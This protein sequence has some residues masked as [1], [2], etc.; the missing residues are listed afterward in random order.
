M[1]AFKAGFFIE[2]GQK[3]L[4]NKIK[5]NILSCIL[6]DFGCILQP[7]DYKTQLDFYKNFFM[8][9]LTTYPIGYKIRRLRELKGMKQETLAKTM[10][11]TRQ[12]ISK[13]EQSETVEE[14]ILNRVADALE[15]STDAIRK[16][17]EEAVLN[18]ISST[19][20]HTSGLINY[21]PTF[22]FNPVDKLVELYE[23]LLQSEKD[24]Y[25]QLETILK[26]NKSVI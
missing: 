16:F 8:P 22:N 10:G 19:L 17:N 20:H 2:Q 18:I 4:R 15:L 3:Y 5:W 25:D 21:S 12:A 23:R 24:K 1:A 6:S 14:D 11:I 26:K 9:D 13:I 7:G